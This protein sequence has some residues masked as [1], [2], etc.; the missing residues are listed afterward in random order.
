MLFY[1]GG[2]ENAALSDGAIKGAKQAA[3]PQIS[4][5]THRAHISS[6]VIHSSV[7]KIL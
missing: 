5:L 6:V 7:K 4:L 3:V 2:D 1:L